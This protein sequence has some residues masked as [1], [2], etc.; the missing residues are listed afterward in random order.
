MITSAYVP[1][2][3]AWIIFSDRIIAVFGDANTITW[4]ATVKGLAFVAITAIRLVLAV[5]AVPAKEA[6]EIMCRVTMSGLA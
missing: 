4:I 1:F 3:T 6:E 5:R 2:A